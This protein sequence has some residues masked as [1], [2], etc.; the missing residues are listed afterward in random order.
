MKKAGESDQ[1]LNILP[2]TIRKTLKPQN[3]STKPYRTMLN[4]QEAAKVGFL[5]IL[6]ISTKQDYLL[7]IAISDV[8]RLEGPG[9]INF[10]DVKA[11]VFQIGKI[12][13]DNGYSV[14]YNQSVQYALLVTSQ[15]KKSDASIKGT[16]SYVDGEGKM[17]VQEENYTQRELISTAPF[18]ISPLLAN[19]PTGKV[20]VNAL[21]FEADYV[22]ALMKKG[23]PGGV[24]DLSPASLK[25]LKPVSE[26]LD[27]KEFRMKIMQIEK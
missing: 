18:D 3:L 16:F 15:Y 20:K 10:D 14:W 19:L 6:G 2:E 12:Y 4:Q 21:K 5:G 22:N 26:K 11:N 24:T 8:W 1:Y 17:Y 13:Y 9:F 25:D 27:S 23:V 7:E